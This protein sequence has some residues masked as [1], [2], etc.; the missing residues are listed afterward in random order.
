MK[1]VVMSWG[2]TK[3]I[4]PAPSSYSNEKRIVKTAGDEVG[5]VGIE[6]LGITCGCRRP[7][8]KYRCPD[9][10]EVLPC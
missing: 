10:D 6:F 3:E 5:V 8:P 7:D 1:M 4:D 9:E 2:V